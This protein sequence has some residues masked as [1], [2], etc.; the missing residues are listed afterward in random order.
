MSCILVLC[1]GWTRANQRSYLVYNFVAF[2]DFPDLSERRHMN[3]ILAVLIVQL[4]A[5]KIE[6]LN[7]QF[8]GVT[9]GIDTHERE[10]LHNTVESA[11]GAASVILN[12]GVIEQFFDVC[13]AGT[14]DILTW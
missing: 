6:N 14:G 2:S 8:D 5:N 7:N 13:I 11:F 12:I 4:E 10:H 9:T 3:P 1:F